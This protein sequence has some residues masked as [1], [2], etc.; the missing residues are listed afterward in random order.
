MRR[1]PNPNP[2]RKRAGQRYGPGRRSYSDI[3]HVPPHRSLICVHPCSSVVHAL[4]A[5]TALL[6]QTPRPRLPSA[7]LMR[8]LTR[9]SPR[10]THNRRSRAIR[11]QSRPFLGL[12]VPFVVQFSFFRAVAARSAHFRK[13]ATRRSRSR[14][15]ITARRSAIGDRERKKGTR[16]RGIKKTGSREQGTGIRER[17]AMKGSRDRGIDRVSPSHL[18]AFVPSSDNQGAQPGGAH[19]RTPWAPSIPRPQSQR[20]YGPTGDSVV[21]L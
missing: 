10:A 14:H 20:L 11:R 19:K 9:Y 18:R 7:V 8:G 21:T 17:A 4:Q 6:G 3:D 13:F 12:F 16:E 5:P 2:S 1:A 15:N